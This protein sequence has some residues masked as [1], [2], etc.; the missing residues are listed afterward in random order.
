[1]WI[2][3]D[4][5]SKPSSSADDQD[6][7][8]LPLEVAVELSPVALA[9]IQA[10]SAPLP[11]PSSPTSIDGSPSGMPS[12]SQSQRMGRTRSMS[13]PRCGAL[14]RVDVPR[15]ELLVE[16][17][18]TQAVDHTQSGLVGPHSTSPPRTARR[19]AGRSSRRPR[20]TEGRG[21]VGSSCPSRD[22]LGRRAPGT[23]PV[24]LGM[25]LRGDFGARV[26]R[27]AR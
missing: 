9:A 21:Y 26:R 4:T 23:G 25:L 10:V 17:V 7:D 6:R 19:S 22:L 20:G 27:R 15:P 11:T 24:P 5:D 13:T 14:P 16:A 1:M 8:R 2:R 12:P 18:E 3:T